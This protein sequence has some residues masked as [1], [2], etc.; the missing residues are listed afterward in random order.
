MCAWY[1]QAVH[2][3]GVDVCMRMWWR[4]VSAALKVVDMKNEASSGAGWTIGENG[5]P[6]LPI[7]SVLIVL[8]V[9]GV[10]LEAASHGPVLSLFMPRV[11]QVGASHTLHMQLVALL[12]CVPCMHF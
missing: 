12:I 10:I 6:K 9:G 11:L 8:G 5:L 1:T 3:R 4:R 7:N 2:G